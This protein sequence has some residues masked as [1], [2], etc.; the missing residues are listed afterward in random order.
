MSLSFDLSHFGSK[1]E[2]YDLIVIGGGPAGTSAAIYAA[3]ANLRT[4]VID[5]GATAGALGITAKIS[6]YPGVPGPVSGLELVETMREQARSFGAEFLT[7]K[8]VGV[9]LQSTPKV[10]M[11]GTNTFETKAILLAT[12]SMGRNHSAPGEAE[13]LGR[14]VS[15]CATCDGAFFKEQ[16]VAVVG[17]NDEALEEALFLTK[18]A[19]QVHLVVPT[20]DLK[21]SPALTSEVITHAKIAVKTATRLKEIYGNGQVEGVRLLPRSGQEE[22]LAVTGVFVYLQGNQPITDYLMGQLETSP[23]GCLVVDRDMQTNLPG[24]FAVGDLLC[25]HIKQAVI[26]AADG[27]IAAI[28]VDKYIHQRDNIRVDWK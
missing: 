6:N 9:D 23:E 10:V 4:L 28:A 7:D 2:P 25:T 17:N 16:S 8:V 15:Y 18:F 12:G 26:A 22:N 19:G 11:A 20:P 21:A 24:V 5:K 3:R 1:P 27:V 13:F 14:G